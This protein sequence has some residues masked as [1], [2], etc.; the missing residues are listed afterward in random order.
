MLVALFRSQATSTLQQ[1]PSLDKVLLNYSHVNLR[2][3]MN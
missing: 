3:K 2:Y 1:D